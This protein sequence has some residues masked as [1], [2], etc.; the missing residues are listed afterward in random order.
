[1]LNEKYDSM[2]AW[3]DGSENW[4]VTLDTQ[5]LIIQ[6]YIDA[7][8]LVDDLYKFDL[9]CYCLI[10]HTNPTIAL[11]HPGKMRICA[12]KYAAEKG[13]SLWMTDEARF[14]GANH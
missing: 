6:E 1:M 3:M 10:A 5:S 14:Q 4:A 12:K 2:T 11:F 13:R 7:P 8:L 9:R